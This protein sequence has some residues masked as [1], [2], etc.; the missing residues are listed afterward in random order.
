M[1]NW[2]SF[3]LHTSEARQGRI[4]GRRKFCCVVWEGSY[5][6]CHKDYCNEQTTCH[7]PTYKI[8][9][10]TGGRG[11]DRAANYFKSACLGCFL[12]GRNSS[13]LFSKQRALCSLCFS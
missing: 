9:Q 13:V 11:R 6:T 2:I 7:D 4:T 5:Q 12:T 3:N 10:S 1:A 8:G